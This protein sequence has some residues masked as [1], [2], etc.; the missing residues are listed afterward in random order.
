M[1]LGN[2]GIRGDCGRTGNRRTAS[3]SLEPALTAPVSARGGRTDA[4]RSASPR[5]DHG[6]G[7]VLVPIRSSSGGR[8]AR[9]QKM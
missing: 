6:R 8:A 4:D 1:V 2:F 3:I 7:G 5:K 9:R